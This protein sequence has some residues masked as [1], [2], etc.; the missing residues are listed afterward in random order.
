MRCFLVVVPLL[1]AALAD[2]DDDDEEVAR[3][4]VVRLRGRRG[5]DAVAVASA[6]A[7]APPPAP[8]PPLL[9]AADAAVGVELARACHTGS[10]LVATGSRTSNSSRLC[11]INLARP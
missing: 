1:D 5:S 2:E 10:G 9:V 6:R 4:R 11:S 7:P 8:P 3:G